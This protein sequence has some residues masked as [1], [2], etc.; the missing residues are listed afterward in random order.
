[1]TTIKN[2]AVRGVLVA[3]IKKP[4][5]RARTNRDRKWMDDWL[6]AVLWKEMEERIEAIERYE[7]TPEEIKEMEEGFDQ[8]EAIWLAETHGIMEPVRKR[9]PRLAKLL[10]PPPRPGKGKRFPKNK[11]YAALHS[12]LYSKLSQAVWDAERI[13]AIWKEHYRPKPKGYGL[14]ED[15]AARM[16]GLQVHQVAEWKASRELPKRTGRMRLPLLVMRDA[17]R[18]RKKKGV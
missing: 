2:A 5:Q 3:E 7:Q 11:F 1:V 13:R 8:G 10:N 16:W 18:E 14:A 4:P 17:E 12:P 9:F 6:E 15:I